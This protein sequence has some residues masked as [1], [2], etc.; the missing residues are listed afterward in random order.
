MKTVATMCIEIVGSS[1]G[2]IEMLARLCN[3]I[4]VGSMCY[5]VSGSILKVRIDEVNKQEEVQPTK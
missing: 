1:S 3:S 4:K 2:V 5:H